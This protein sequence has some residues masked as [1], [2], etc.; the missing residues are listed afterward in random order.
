MDRSVQQ[1]SLDGDLIS[2]SRVIGTDVYNDADEH[3]G[4]VDEIM[5]HRQS[6]KIAYAV[7]SF[8]GFL[9]IGEKYHPLP[10]SVLDYDP[11]KGGYVVKMSKELLRDAPSFARDDIVESDLAWR[12]PVHS[13]YGVAPYWPL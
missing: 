6:D 4:T 8:G 11:L 1:Q 9:G 3:L 7:M 12:E 5:L 2:T 10:W 13:Y